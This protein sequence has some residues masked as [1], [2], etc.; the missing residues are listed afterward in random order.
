MKK[1][2]A[3]CTVSIS[4]VFV[5]ILAAQGFFS[6]DKTY[7]KGNFYLG[8]GEQ[9]KAALCYIWASVLDSDS[10]DAYG[11]ALAAIENNDN[12]Y[13]SKFIKTRA[14]K[15]NIYGKKLERYTVLHSDIE[16]YHITSY[17][18]DGI[19][20]EMFNSRGQLVQKGHLYQT[21]NPWWIPLKLY[22][23]HSNGE[24]ATETEYNS[25]NGNKVN[26]TVYNE[27][28]NILSQTKYSH[29]DGHKTGE[30]YYNDMGLIST[31]IDYN[32][33]DE[34]TRITYT[35]NDLGKV[36]TETYHGLQEKT[37]KYSYDDNGRVL[38]RVEKKLPG[39]EI[40]SVTDF[41]ADGKT[42]IFVEDKWNSQTKTIKVNGTVSKVEK[43]WKSQVSLTDTTPKMVPGEIKYYDKG[44]IVKEEMYRSFSGRLDSISYYTDGV[45]C[46][47]ETYN[48]DEEGFY[49]Y[50]L[51]LY[52]GQG[53]VVER[54]INS[55]RDKLYTIEKY[56]FDNL[57]KYEKYER[58]NSKA[59]LVYRS[60]KDGKTYTF[61]EEFFSNTNPYTPL[62]TTIRDTRINS[63]KV[64]FP[65]A[66]MSGSRFLTQEETEQV[67][68][69]LALKEYD[70]E[71]PLECFLASSFPYGAP[72]E[73]NIS[74]LVSAMSAA[75]YR[76]NDENIFDISILD[77]DCEA[78]LSS[79]KKSGE[80]LPYDAI[81]ANGRQYYRVPY[82]SVNKLL[83]KYMGI[84]L[85]D[86]DNPDLPVKSDQYRSFYT[87]LNRSGDNFICI[88]G[89]IN[90]NWLK[91]YSK[92][93]TRI[94]RRNGD[95]FYIYAVILEYNA[96]KQ[97]VY[98]QSEKQA[99]SSQEKNYKLK[100]ISIDTAGKSTAYK[101]AAAL[102]T[103]FLQQKQEELKQKW[104]G[105]FSY[106]ALSYALTDLSDDG[107]P[108]LITHNPDPFEPYNVYM[109]VNGK[110]QHIDTVG[111]YGGDGGVT[112]LKDSYIVGRVNKVDYNNYEFYRYKNDGTPILFEF[113]IYQDYYRDDM[114]YMINGEYISKQNYI[115][116]T[117]SLYRL[118][119][120]KN[121]DD[122]VWYS[123]Q[124][125]Q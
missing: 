112:V 111:G 102:Y 117:R 24:V 94:F 59:N 14:K 13:I 1:I 2:I 29:L 108:E 99:V 98:I 37:V 11:G 80:N 90:D 79:L 54:T 8:R 88:G 48:K 27:N 18:R 107:V 16:K 65:R 84:Q 19:K 100:D 93:K 73:I 21:A 4:F 125:E 75:K 26:K 58:Y 124:E 74:A 122:I 116:K 9:K 43:W 30:Q 64:D 46:R 86:V 39:G 120:D 52:D 66:D 15:N 31:K 17:V 106:L 53:R 76:Q 49:L 25:T 45:L 109:I 67:N 85:S 97:N 32:E 35:Y 51:M 69:A 57:G 36:L 81:E 70:K 101:N 63:P 77:M 38:Q 3:L 33:D 105:K 50:G 89:K 7:E 6:Y 62:Y 56:T 47:A 96:D 72:Q 55:A 20:V 119:G 78:E 115:S 34:Y 95:D 91:L 103:T 110:V 23:Y 40:I 61:K 87:D 42:E 60:V 28:G 10:P 71:H 92:T 5:I 114:K 121:I 104:N 82:S 113:G 68:T 118:L 123:M 12:G 41:F 83:G 22:T 44:K